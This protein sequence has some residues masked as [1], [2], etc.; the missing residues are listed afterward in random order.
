M[1]ISIPEKWKKVPFVSGKNTSINRDTGIPF[2][3]L[4]VAMTVNDLWNNM[5]KSLLGRGRKVGCS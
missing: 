1:E 5:S 2:Q 4:N 3:T